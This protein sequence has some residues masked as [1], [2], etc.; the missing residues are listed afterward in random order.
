MIKELKNADLIL[1]SRRIAGGNEIGRNIFRK[2]VTLV[3]NLYIKVMLG[4]KIKDFNFNKILPLF[5]PAVNVLNF[6]I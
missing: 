1:G 4:I 3:A 6:K 5:S 2:F